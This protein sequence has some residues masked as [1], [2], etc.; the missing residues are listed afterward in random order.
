[1]LTKSEKLARDERHAE[2]HEETTAK[3]TALTGDRMR[4]G[5]AGFS[6]FMQEKF[7]EYVPL[8]HH[9]MTYERKNYMKQHSKL[10]PAAELSPFNCYTGG[11]G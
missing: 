7:K 11:E 1:M 10:T 5:E 2:E 9:M 4:N 6:D 3:V 8:K